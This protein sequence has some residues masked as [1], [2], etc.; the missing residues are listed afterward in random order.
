MLTGNKSNAWM[1]SFSAQIQRLD[2][3]T[4][5]KLLVIDDGPAKDSWHVE[6]VGEE[7]SDI[8]YLR[9][10]ELIKLIKT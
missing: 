7:V 9:I 10:K 5:V 3:Y 8:L 2:P 4:V 6:A 1:T